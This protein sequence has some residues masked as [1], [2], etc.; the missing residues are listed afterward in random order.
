[1]RNDSIGLRRAS[2]SRPTRR[3]HAPHLRLEQPEGRLAPAVTFTQT[4]LVSD[5]PGMDKARDPNLVNAWGRTLGTNS[6]LWVAENGPGMAESFDG[7]GQ[8]V[9]VRRHH[10]GPRGTGTALPRRCA[11]PFPAHAGGR[12]PPTAPLAWY[13]LSSRG[14]QQNDWFSMLPVLKLPAQNSDTRG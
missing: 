14:S 5:V 9:P 13:S 7:T 3:R 10:P 4:N 2:H 1:M 8:A 12:C 6:G 11:T